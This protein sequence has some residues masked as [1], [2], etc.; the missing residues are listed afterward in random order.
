MTAQQIYVLAIGNLSLTENESDTDIEAVSVGALNQLLDESLRIEN[1]IRKRRKYDWERA[2]KPVIT[3]A[4]ELLMEELKEAPL[5]SSL[6]DDI[7]YANTL[8]VNAL[9]QGLTSFLWTDDENNYNA[10]DWRGRYVAALNGAEQFVPEYVQN[11]YS[12]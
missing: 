2:G 1:S 3:P 4:E 5:I 7:P 9:V 8:C 6:N 12:I 11:I 10:V